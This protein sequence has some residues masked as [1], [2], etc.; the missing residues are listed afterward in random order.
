MENVLHG[1]QHMAR[2]EYMFAITAASQNEAASVLGR[3]QASAVPKFSL[4]PERRK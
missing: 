4:S 2:R 3:L 1:A